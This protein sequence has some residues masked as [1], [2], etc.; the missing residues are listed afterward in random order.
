[1]EYT[2]WTL[3]DEITLVIKKDTYRDCG[4]PQAYLVNPKDKKQLQ[5][6]IEWG[7][8]KKYLYDE[9]GN[10]IKDDRGYSKYELIEPEIHTIKN[11]GF[12]VE[13]LDSAHGSYQGGKQSF[14]NCLVYNEDLKF[15]I[16]INSELL[17]Y[18]IKQSTFTNGRSTETY[19]S[20]EKRIK[21]RIIAEM[22]YE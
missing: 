12:T 1:M 16:G 10:S 19:R 2:G 20:K 15:V 22:I 6:A 5:R 8:D 7:T 14:W 9:N 18:A 4:Y 11:E 13:F 3:S 17:L 21:R